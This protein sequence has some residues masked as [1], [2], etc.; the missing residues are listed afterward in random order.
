MTAS[1]DLSLSSKRRSDVSQAS[2][3]SQSEAVSQSPTYSPDM[4]RRPPVAGRGNAIMPPPPTTTH[5][6]PRAGYD[7]RATIQCSRPIH[8]LCMASRMRKPRV[9][10]GLLRDSRL[11]NQGLLPPPTMTMATAMATLRLCY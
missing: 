6:Q 7:P 3:G 11:S 5:G 2:S 9:K 1:Q 4:G 10:A 8:H